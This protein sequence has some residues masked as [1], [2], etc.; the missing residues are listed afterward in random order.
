MTHYVDFF[1]SISFSFT[2]RELISHLQ[3][4]GKWQEVNVVADGILGFAYL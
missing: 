3:A 4:C 2:P 1:F